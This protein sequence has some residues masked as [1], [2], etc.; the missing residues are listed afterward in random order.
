MSSPPPP[1][2]QLKVDICSYGVSSIDFMKDAMISDSCVNKECSTGFQER[3]GMG[4]WKRETDP[5]A[6]GWGCKGSFCLSQRST[7]QLGTEGKDG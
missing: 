2:A 3:K 6:G 4:M 5:P 7:Q 1:T